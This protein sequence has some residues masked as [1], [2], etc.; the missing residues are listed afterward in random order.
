M[1]GLLILLRTAAVTCVI[2][3]AFL[4]TLWAGP[5]AEALFAPVLRNQVLRGIDRLPDGRLC[6]T[7]AFDKVRAAEVVDAGWTLR[8]GVQLYPYQRLETVADSEDVG[9]AVVT[10]PVRRGQWSRKCVDLPYGLRDRPF[11]LTGFVEYRTAATGL[12]WTIRQPTA[13]AEVP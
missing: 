1:S 2:A 13:S 5:D 7:A 3:V 6:F 10:R 11:R 8:D 9:Q 4:C 12:F